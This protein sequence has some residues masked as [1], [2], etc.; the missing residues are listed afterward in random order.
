MLKKMIS[1]FTVTFVLIILS[2]CSDYFDT[3]QIQN[4][5]MLVDS[6]ID[7]QAWAEKGYEGLQNIGEKYEVD[8]SYEENVTT[9]QETMEAVDT[10]VEDGVNLIFGH[11]NIYGAHF[12]NIA[13]TYPDVH[14]VYFNGGYVDENVTSLNFDSHAMGFFAGM[15]AG[16]MTETDQIGMIADYEWQP[17][18]EGFYEGVNYQNPAAEVQVDFNSDWNDTNTAPEIY[19]EMRDDEVDIFYPTGDAYSTDIIEQAEEDGLYAIGYVSDQS[20]IAESTVLTST[21]Q[22]VD[23]LYELVAEEF[24]AESLGGSIMTFDFQDELISLGQFSPDVPE[25]FQNEV[26]EAVEEYVNN[27]LLPNQ[28]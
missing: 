16:E 20:E 1:L 25:Y 24:N 17:E 3:G 21:V 12:A 27:G 23:K 6:S 4:V 5:G 7:N 13:S 11:S 8:V 28:S 19:G 2:G 14:F 26:K 22:H 10:F 9:E 18:I 15:V